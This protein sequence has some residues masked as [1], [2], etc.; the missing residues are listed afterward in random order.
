MDSFL[1]NI[2][3]HRKIVRISVIFGLCVLIS[4][5]LIILETKDLDRS[6]FLPLFIGSLFGL[7]LGVPLLLILVLRLA[8]DRIKV[9]INTDGIETGKLGFIPFRDISEVKKPINRYGNNTLLILK[10]K[11][12]RKLSFAPTS[13]FGGM[14]NSIY[15]SFTSQLDL[16][17]KNNS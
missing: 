7:M 6:E 12:G 1:L 10:L 13:R 3:D 16:R 11:D 2:S 8:S 4:L 9:T 15:E 17:L 14:A 5:I